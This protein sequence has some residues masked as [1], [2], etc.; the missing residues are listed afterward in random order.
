MLLVLLL[1]HWLLFLNL[2]CLVL[3]LNGSCLRL[4]SWSPFSFLSVI[5]ILRNWIQSLALKTTYRLKT[6]VPTS[7]LLITDYLPTIYPTAYSKIC[8]LTSNG[9]TKLIASKKQ[10]RDCLLLPKYGFFIHLLVRSQTLST[11][12][13]IHPKFHYFLPFLSIGVLQSN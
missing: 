12:F 3:L 11:S 9:R 6:S 8:L 1:S 5:T 10:N 13:K 4:Q 7:P 2:L